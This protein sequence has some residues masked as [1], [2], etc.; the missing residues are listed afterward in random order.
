MTLTLPLTM[1]SFSVVIPTFNRPRALRRCLSALARA[2]YPRQHLEVIVVD[3]GSENASD[4]FGVANA[5]SDQL[6]VKVIRQP[7]AGPAAAR[8]TGSSAARNEFLAFT[9]DDCTPRCDWLEKLA[10]VLSRR[11]DA[12]VGGRRRNALPHNRYAVASQ[13]II[14]VVFAHFNRDAERATF[15]P[16]DNMALPRQRLLEIGGFSSSF[17]WSEDRDLCD[18]WSARGWPL[19]RADDAIVD[20]AHDMGLAGFFS[21]HFGYGRGAWRFH[22]TRA[23]RGARRLEVEGSFYLKCFREP[24]RTHPR[25][26]AIPLAVLLG[27]WQLA[28]AAGFFYEAL[29]QARARRDDK[30]LTLTKALTTETAGGDG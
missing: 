25:R 14:D 17:R 18:R 29:L 9:D 16:S 13:T 30:L 21:Q 27:I 11:P 19:I 23:R 4:V 6:K 3:D 1:P 28:N 5:F 15:F 22:Q 26:R 12:L 7:N 20:H 24:F 10:E 8:N 2:N